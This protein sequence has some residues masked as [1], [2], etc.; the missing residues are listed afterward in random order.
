M[1]PKVGDEV[2]IYWCDVRHEDDLTLDE[3]KKLQP[4]PAVTYGK[5]LVQN[6]G[7][8]IIAST[9]FPDEN[10]TDY[11][12]ILVIPHCLISRIRKIKEEI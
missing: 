2:K 5:I 10:G 6:D 11:R 4:A 9:E 1:K 7:W 8:V 3:I 12:G